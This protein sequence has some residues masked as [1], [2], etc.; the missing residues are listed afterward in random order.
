M[1]AE[2]LETLSA[3]VMPKNR[4][5]FVLPF[6]ENGQPNQYLSGTFRQT[7]D[8]WF[9][10]AFF[11]RRYDDARGAGRVTE[12]EALRDEIEAALGGWQWNEHEELIEMV[13]SQASAALGKGTSIFVHTWKTTRT[14]ETS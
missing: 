11:I 4:T 6:R 5:V 7:I 1:T 14:L 9:L 13:A 10:T 2:D 12:F 8:V 3:G